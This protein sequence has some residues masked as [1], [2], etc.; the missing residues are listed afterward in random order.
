MVAGE[1]PHFAGETDPAIGEENLSLADAA[2]IENDLPRRRIA[3]MVF[4]ANAEIIITKRNP[5]RFAAPADMNHAALKG[6]AR[7]EGR[8]GLRGLLFEAGDKGHSGDRYFQ[9]RHRLSVL[10]SKEGSKPAW[11]SS[12]YDQDS[13]I[14]I[15]ALI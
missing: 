2:R 13:A 12:P 9:G 8:T 3:C 1:L 11:R 14:R 6:K 10:F 4:V 15:P 5:H 7:L